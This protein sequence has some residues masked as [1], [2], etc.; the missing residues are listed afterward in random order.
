M[1]LDEHTNHLDLSSCEILEDALMDY[2][3]TIIAVSHD[4]YFINR[5]ATAI[6]YFDN[7]ALKRL[8]GNYE[9][10]VELKNA[11]EQPHTAD[12]K[13]V[14]SGGLAYKKQK[15]IEA[16][17][18]KLKTAYTKCEAEIEELENT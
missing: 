3:G 4:R 17:K 10:Y 16:R 6:L 11:S 18:R 12:K 15:E 9:R 8:D 13:Q 7:G 1:L 2:E 5:I 14:G